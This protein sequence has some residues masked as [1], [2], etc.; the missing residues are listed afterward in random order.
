MVAVGGG[1]IDS[2]IVAYTFSQ[3]ISLGL[4]QGSHLEEVGTA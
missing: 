3:I 2:I 1:G 4:I